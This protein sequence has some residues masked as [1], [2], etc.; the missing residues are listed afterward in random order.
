MGDKVSPESMLRSLLPF[1]IQRADKQSLGQTLLGLAGVKVSDVTPFE[2]LTHCWAE[3]IEKARKDGLFPAEFADLI[4]RGDFQDLTSRAKEIVKQADPE[5]FAAEEEKARKA[6]SPYQAFYDFQDKTRAEY[7]PVSDG[8]INLLNTTENAYDIRKAKDLFEDELIKALKAMPFP[9][10]TGP[11]REKS[12]IQSLV[13]TYYSLYDLAKNPDG[14]QNWDKLE[15]MQAQMRADV[16]AQQGQQVGSYFS[17][18]VERQQSEMPIIALYQSAQPFVSDYF[19]IP[20]GQFGAERA[21]W[22]AENPLANATLAYLGY[23]REVKSL[24]AGDILQQVAPQ[25][26]PV[27]DLFLQDSQ[28]APN[29]PNYPGAREA[30]DIYFNLPNDSATRQEWLREHPEANAILILSGYLSS[31]KT[32]EA[33]NLVTSS[34]GAK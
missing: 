21:A 25:R 13:Q 2:K 24:E 5:L 17:W 7:R 3:A 1:S 16:T 18:S 11:G 30:R 20:F 34:G 10:S 9:E 33:Y 14:S 31:A 6:G 27:Y 15:A 29:N 28:A 8:L 4:K 19:G 23:V 22:L 12:Q 32:Y 26:Q